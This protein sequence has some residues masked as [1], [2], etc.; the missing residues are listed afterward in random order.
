ML[1]GYYMQKDFSNPRLVF[2]NKS[3]NS[4]TSNI[5]LD[6]FYLVCILVLNTFAYIF[7]SFVIDFSN[8]LSN[9]F[10]PR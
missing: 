3:T 4:L 1:N 10:Y 9:S 5:D 8:I 2:S 7:S 6:N